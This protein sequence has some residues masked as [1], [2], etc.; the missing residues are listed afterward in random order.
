MFYSVQIFMSNNLCVTV[1]FWL[2]LVT[3]LCLHNNIKLV[4]TY[5]KMT[6][7][8]EMMTIVVKYVSHWVQSIPPKRLNKVSH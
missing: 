2:L 8:F 5:A 1:I 4:E 6:F 7:M 3:F